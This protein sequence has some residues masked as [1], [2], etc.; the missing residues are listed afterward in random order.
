MAFLV[1]P[2]DAT[3][4]WVATVATLAW[5]HPHRRQL[6][7]TGLSALGLLLGMALFLAYNH[8]LAGEWTGAL[9]TLSSPRN[10]L[11]F[12]PDV[13]IE[14]HS[15]WQA[16]MNLNYNAAVMSADLFGW[17]ISSLCFLFGLVCFGRQRW[18]HR[19]ALI[20][21]ASVAGAYFLYWYHGVCFGARFYFSLL[22]L[23]LIL[24]VEGIYQAPC[25]LR[26]RHRAIRTFVT[27][28]FGFS[29]V[30]YV[31]LVALFAPYHD[32]WGVDGRLRELSASGS[33]ER[34]IAFVGPTA[35][36]FLPG[37]VDNALEPAQGKV[38]YAVESGPRDALLIARFPERR[39]VH[40][41][42]LA[43]GHDEPPWVSA[44]LRRG[45]VRELFKDIHPRRF[46]TE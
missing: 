14:G 32:Q 45:Y 9:L 18:E 25:I 38:M 10:R 13:G 39:V 33:V 36:D 22:P 37:F 12:G 1:R 26:I 30:V 41:T 31:P 11:G 23:L 40:Y 29:L 8:A 15:L 43:V 42:H 16:A 20:I 19:L 28:C 2:L 3:A 35:A 17:P 7:G 6:A 46:L 27:L 44:I 21:V 34:S 24:T 4:V 5:R